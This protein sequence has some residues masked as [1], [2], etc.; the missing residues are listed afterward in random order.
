MWDRCSYN[1]LAGRDIH[2]VPFPIEHRPDLGL[3]LLFSMVVQR[4]LHVVRAGVSEF[5]LDLG[6]KVRA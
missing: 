3:V 2:E 4:S 1:L 5:G 6:G